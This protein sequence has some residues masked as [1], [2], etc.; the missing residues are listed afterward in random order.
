MQ[1]A[2]NNSYLARLFKK[3]GGS[4]I[5]ERIISADRIHVSIVK[6]HNIAHAPMPEGHPGGNGMAKTAGNGSSYTQSHRPALVAFGTH[7]QRNPD[8]RGAVRKIWTP[9]KIF[10]DTNVLLDVLARREQFYSVSAE[11]WPLSESGAV[12]GC[13]SAISFNNI[14]REDGN[15]P[16]CNC[17]N[18]ISTM[19]VKRSIQVVVQIK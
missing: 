5:T 7:F 6:Q 1:S 12:Q 2:N 4:G 18:P 10:L 17:F 19:P 9:M 8:N 13:I 15:E 11:V 16:A 3:I 14:Y